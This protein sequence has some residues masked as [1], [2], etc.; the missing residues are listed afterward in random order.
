M[1][2]LLKDCTIHVPSLVLQWKPGIR[3]LTPPHTHCHPP[4]AGLDYSTSQFGPH[5]SVVGPGSLAIGYGSVSCLIGS[6][7][8]V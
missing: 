5:W 4:P 1:I 3:S 8:P 7:G 2:L 6:E